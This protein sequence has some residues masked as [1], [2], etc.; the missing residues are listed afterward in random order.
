MK[1]FAL[2]A[3]LAVATVSM[4]AMVGP[5]HA[6]SWHVA[7]AGGAFAGWS[8]VGMT[9][10][11]KGK[12]YSC[13]TPSLSGSV[14]GSGGGIVNGPTSIVQW[15][16][17]ATLTPRYTGC[18]NAGINYTWSCGVENLNTVGSGYSGGVTTTQA[19]SAGLST[20]V[21]LSGIVCTIKPTSSPS[22]NC[23]TVTG[24]VPG[25]Y[26]NPANLATDPGSLTVNTPGQS[27]TAAS[28]GGCVSAFGTGP[29]TFGQTTYGVTGT[30][31]AAPDIWAN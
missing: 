20:N 3:V 5:A 29:A 11:V 22:I 1:N 9:F 8:G 16:A 15:N 7:P 25:V 12:T 27:L 10:K 21:Q 28:V 2:L 19:G 17:V 23:T 26:T 18:T 30:S 6:A 31:V 14:T 4:F 24:T 13:T